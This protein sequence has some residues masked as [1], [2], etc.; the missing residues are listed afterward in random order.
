MSD[1]SAELQP[2]TSRVVPGVPG[3]G[4]QLVP[5]IPIWTDLPL[6]WYQPEFKPYAE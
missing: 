3:S 6:D 5:D 2:S 4:I 1:S